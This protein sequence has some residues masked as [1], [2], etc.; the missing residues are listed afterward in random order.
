MN[1]YVRGWPRIPILIAAQALGCILPEVSAVSV[2]SPAEVA[3]GPSGQHASQ[4]AKEAST[5]DASPPRMSDAPEL[6]GVSGT[7]ASDAATPT[8]E[9]SSPSIDAST[10]QPDT[11]AAGEPAPSNTATMG[12]CTA[13]P[14]PNGS[15]CSLDAQCSAGSCYLDVCQDPG[16]YN[17]GCNS[18]ADCQT[19]LTCN[20]LCKRNQGAA[21]SSSIECRYGTCFRGV[22]QAPQPAGHPCDTAADCKRPS[23][24]AETICQNPRGEPC[25]VDTDCYMSVCG[26][27]FVC[28]G[29]DLPDGERCHDDSECLSGSCAFDDVCAQPADS[30]HNCN[31]DPDCQPGLYCFV[32]ERREVGGYC[33]RPGTHENGRTCTQDAE[34][35]TDSCRNS[36]CASPVGTGQGCD[37]DPDC[38]AGLFCS[39]QSV[40]VAL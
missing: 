2:S 20:K 37:S 28:I 35:M 31:S 8:S 33:K 25:S 5:P 24:C 22:C 12:Q 26:P 17:S 9:A 14:C 34:C 36:V 7:T 15:A 32:R 39:E 40:C 30:P 10:P 1:K 18:D 16:P 21:C 3:E 4:V 19:M 29:H 27:T 6:A 11:S 23:M 38:A 13:E